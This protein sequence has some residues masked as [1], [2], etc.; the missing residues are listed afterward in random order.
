MGFDYGASRRPSLGEVFLIIV[1]CYH[2]HPLTDGGG[3]IFVVGGPID[4][5][6]FSSL[7]R[8]FI[9]LLGNT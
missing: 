9:F 7:G 1:D 8:L 6:C 2:Q 5:T 3:R 4:C